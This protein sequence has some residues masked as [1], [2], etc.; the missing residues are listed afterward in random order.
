MHQYEVRILFRGSVSRVYV[1]A[2]NGNHAKL[3]VKAQYGNQVV[4]LSAKPAK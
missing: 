2:R 4:V 1:E 3:L